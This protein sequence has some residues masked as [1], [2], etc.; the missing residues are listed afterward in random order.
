MPVGGGV[1]TYAVAGRQYV[2]V[3]AGLHAPVTWKVSSP[4]ARMLVFALP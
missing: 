2:A 1:V 4:K 3:A